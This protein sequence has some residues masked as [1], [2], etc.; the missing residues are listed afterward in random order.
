MKYNFHKSKFYQTLARV[1]EGNFARYLSFHLHQLFQKLNKYPNDIVIETAS[2]CNLNCTICH[3]VKAELGRKNR[4]M[5][6]A[7]FKKI[8]DDITP[9]C[10]TIGVSFCGE[11]LLNKDIFKMIRYASGK[12]MCVSMLTNGILLNADARMSILDSRLNFMAISMDGASN[13]TYESIR[14]G[15]SFDTL[16]ENI[17][18]L[19]KE[20]NQRE[21][22]NPSI[23]LQMVVTQKNIHEVDI[24]E[25]L[26][27]ELGVDRAYLKSLH[28]DRS[29]EDVAYV[30][31]LEKDYF[32]NSTSLPSR[33]ITNEQ[34]NLE[35]KD[36]GL[37]PQKVRT[38]VITTDGEV[39][40]CCFD[41]FGEHVL[42]NIANQ[43]FWISGIQGNTS[44][45]DAIWL[46][47]ENCLCAPIVSHQITKR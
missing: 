35:L 25:K 43:R 16:V 29:R 1:S 21:L 45:S 41:I 36:K 37:C 44:I 9:I 46:C 2:V 4:F 27:R 7:L 19:V 10:N 34:G 17:R 18:L 15:G 33:Y 31:S 12:G 22:H 42:G 40:P 39:L 8:I 47:T 3:S 23:D 32:V 11:P 5:S 14:I 20:R 6:L 24:F 30:K 38:P 26:A 28:I 13:H